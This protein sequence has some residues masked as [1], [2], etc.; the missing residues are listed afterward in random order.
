MKNILITLF[1]SFAIFIGLNRPLAQTLEITGGIL[2]IGVILT[3]QSSPDGAHSFDITGN[4]FNPFEILYV[5]S[6]NGLFTV[7][8]SGTSGSYTTSEFFTADGSGVVSQTVYVKYSPVNA[9]AVM[10]NLSIYEFQTFTFHEKPVQ[11]IGK[12][13]EILIEGRQV[14]T[15][16]WQEIIDDESNPTLLKGTDFGETAYTVDTTFRTYRITNNLPVGGLNGDLLIFEY[17]PAQKVEIAGS[18]ADQFFVHQEPE[19][20]ISTG[21]DTTL[22]AIGF[23]PTSYG[24]K[25][26]IVTIQNNDPD[27]NPFTFTIQGM[28]VIEPAAVPIAR[29]PTHVDNNNFYANWKQGI[30]GSA[31]GYILDVGLDAQFT[32]FLP[33]YHSWDVGS[34]TSKNITGLEASVT[35]YY[36]VKAYKPGDTSA[37]S[38]TVAVKTAPPVP[39]IMPPSII[40]IDGFYANWTFVGEATGYRLD[41]N[42]SPDFNGFTVLH[43]KAV[44][45]HYMY[46]ENLT[47]GVTYYYRVRSYN[48]HSSEN[49][50]VTSAVTL[51]EKPL[52]IDASQV[53]DEG[54]TA[55]WSFSNPVFVEGFLFDLSTD[56]SFGDF[57]PGYENRPVGPFLQEFVIGLDPG[58]TYY[59]RVRTRY[60]NDTTD[61][62]NTISVATT[63]FAPEVEVSIKVL[64][65]GPFDNGQLSTWLNSGGYLPMDQPFDVIPW[66]YNGP[67][68][69]AGIP[70]GD[71]T[72]WILVDLLTRDTEDTTVFHILGCKAA[73]LRNDGQIVNLSGNGNLFY[74]TVVSG[75]YYVCVHHRNHLPVI[76]FEP[77]TDQG[78]VYTYDFSAVQTKT[79]EQFNG[80]KELVS[81]LW[82]MMAAD[83]NGDAEINT[84]DINDCWYPA[85]NNNGYFQG[86]F[87]MDGQ[88]NTSDKAN[89]WNLN[90]GKGISNT[91]YSIILQ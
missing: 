43:D 16:G 30:G 36:R 67:E 7:S 54:F 91:C 44:T 83:G 78:G 34:L 22:F 21:Y 70:T 81:G 42:T 31:Q 17:S 90:V 49:S 61:Y 75:D 62:S 58:T 48:G 24:L 1:L 69:V 18:H 40:D 32:E 14:I 63:L 27:E 79:Q 57:V 56:P 71:I 20:S 89:L 51:P 88:V 41:V 35:Y 5:D 37:Y 55:N 86:D 15:S 4:G 60:A 52:A 10:I 3:G 13:P 85:L 73:F 50:G 65:E 80:L 33:G 47:G 68:M 59:Y 82:G 39:T 64:L 25:T 74:K 46:V 38:A 2:N 66:N 8:M 53:I 77:L 29:Q 19:S 45:N 23:A 28:G 9:G 26:A 84:K 11:G 72:D 6:P 87:N 12:A 76:S